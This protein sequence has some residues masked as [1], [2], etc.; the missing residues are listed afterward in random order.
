MSVNM[1]CTHVFEGGNAHCGRIFS[2]ATCSLSDGRR[3]AATASHDRSV[4]I[5]S[6]NTFE[7]LRTIDYSD[8]VWRVFIVHY[9]RRPLVVAFVSAEEKIQVSDLL[10][11][12]TVNMFYGR[13]IYSGLF[14]NFPEPVIICASGEEDLSFVDVTTGQSLKTIH[15]GFGKVFRAVVS[16]ST[17]VF[18][19]WNSQ[20]RRS[21]IQTYELAG[22]ENDPHVDISQD[23]HRTASI[24]E[25]DSRDGVT[26]LVITLGAKPMI[27]SGHYDFMVRLW[28]VE[29]KQLVMTLEGK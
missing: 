18:T 29:S 8:F 7:L 9:K 22:I 26:S 1:D 24:F 13:L 28:D 3:I 12:E 16:G 14:Q 11:G 19:T 25:G 23:L 4:K 5:W 21:T 27:C 2:I 6:I 20:N 15:G 10:T 17:L